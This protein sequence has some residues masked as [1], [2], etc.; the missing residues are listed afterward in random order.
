MRDVGG[1]LPWI[2]TPDVGLYIGWKIVALHIAG[3]VS[4]L[5]RAPQRR[6]YRKNFLICAWRRRHPSTCSGGVGNALSWRRFKAFK[7][8]SVITSLTGWLSATFPGLGRTLPARGKVFLGPWIKPTGWLN[9][10]F[11]CSVTGILFH[12]EI[13]FKSSGWIPVAGRIG[14]V[15][16]YLIWV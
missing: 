8:S 9:F 5:L 2:I 10:F 3:N 13:L 6:L 7:S 4:L 1:C 12:F 11:F 14:V 15:F 16:N